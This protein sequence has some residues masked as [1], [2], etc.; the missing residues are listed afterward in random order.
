MPSPFLVTV[1]FLA[2]F[3]PLD[4]MPTSTGASP[5]AVESTVKFVGLPGKTLPGSRPEITITFE[6]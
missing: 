2:T 1:G 3:L 6:I 4:V 5:V